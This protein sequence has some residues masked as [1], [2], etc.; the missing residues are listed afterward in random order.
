MMTSKPSTPKGKTDK[1]DREGLFCPFLGFEDD[2]ETALAY[3]ASYN[4]CFHCRPIAPINLVHQRM[5]CLTSKYEDCPVFTKENLEPIPKG[6][7]GSRPASGKTI[8][9]VPYIVLVAVIIIGMMVAVLFGLIHIPGV[10]LPVFSVGA[11]NTPLVPTATKPKQE[12]TPTPAATATIMPTETEII[13][14]PTRPTPRAL[15]TPF[16]ESPQLVIHKV[17]PG[18]GYISL[19]EKFG[20]TADAIKAINFELPESLWVNTILVIPINTDDVTDLPQFSVREINTE[21]LTIEAYADR[22]GL[23]AKLLKQYN[24]LPNGY[25]F[26]MGELLIIPN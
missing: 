4:F 25:L 11:T 12:Y 15:E 18:E 3:P 17:L 7:R 16:G 19:A 14:F 24:G 22:M 23:D 10:N 26:K 2:P 13:S 6:I 8:R 9:W 5:V 21:G 20:T 1:K